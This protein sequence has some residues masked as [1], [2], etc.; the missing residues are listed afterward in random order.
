MF[1]LKNMASSVTS[2]VFSY[3]SILEKTNDLILRKLSEGQMD[4]RTD[5][6]MNESDIIERCLANV[7]HASVE[8]FCKHRTTSLL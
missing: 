8:L 2:I 1:F 4:G 7:E 3:C 5:R 6:Q